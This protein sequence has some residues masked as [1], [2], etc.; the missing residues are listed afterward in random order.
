V[1]SACESEAQTATHVLL[2][3]NVPTDAD[4]DIDRRAIKTIKC[5]KKTATTATPAAQTL[6]TINPKDSW[7]FIIY[8]TPMQMR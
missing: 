2:L 1:Q 4:T 7:T 5:I 8:T 3:R 6:A